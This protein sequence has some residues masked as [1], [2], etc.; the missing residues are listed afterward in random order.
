M[1]IVRSGN[2]KYQNEHVAIT[3]IGDNGDGWMRIGYTG[4]RVSHIDKN[5]LNIL[6]VDL[7]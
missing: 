6:G 4:L 3:H 7:I 1:K 2:P 5:N